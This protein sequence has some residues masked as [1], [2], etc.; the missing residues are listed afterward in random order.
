VVVPGDKLGDPDRQKTHAD[1]RH[2]LVVGL[3]LPGEL[4][5]AS[6]LV[7]LLEFVDL[8]CGKS[9]PEQTREKKVLVD[10]VFCRA[11]F[12]N[13]LQHHLRDPGSWSSNRGTNGAAAAGA[14]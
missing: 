7:D 8:R 5:P 4:R 10:L 11:P 13:I 12:I 9:L 6:L 3:L 1:H 14:A 2:V